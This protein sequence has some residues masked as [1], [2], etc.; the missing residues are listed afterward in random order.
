MSKNS[1]LEELDSKIN[2]TRYTTPHLTPPT[3]V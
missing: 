1:V 3:E 2:L